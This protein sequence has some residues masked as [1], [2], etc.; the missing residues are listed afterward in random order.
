MGMTLVILTGGIDLSVGSVWAM[1]AVLAASLMS[2][3]WPMVSALAVA[4]LA[5]AA[6]G[7]LSWP[8]ARL[9]VTLER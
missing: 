5:A 8:V 9:A 7:L 4:L 1:T 2:S 3:G 6:V